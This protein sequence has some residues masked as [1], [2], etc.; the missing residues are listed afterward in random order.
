M[1]T[2]A[3]GSK[4]ACRFGYDYQPSRLFGLKQAEDSQLIH[5][6]PFLASRLFIQGLREES[7]RNTFIHVTM[8]AAEESATTILVS[9]KQTRF[10]IE[11]PVYSEVGV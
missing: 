3:E 2:Q 6:P 10:H 8:A 11:N 5:Q 7:S 9:C 4:P 1:V